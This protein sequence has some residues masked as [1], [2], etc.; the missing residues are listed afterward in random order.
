MSTLLGVH[1]GG[2]GLW[3]EVTRADP[4]DQVLSR[5]AARDLW[6]PEE[7]QELWLGARQECGSSL[8]P[9]LFASRKLLRN[10]CGRWQVPPAPPVLPSRVTLLYML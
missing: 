6:F 4:S 7:Q 10:P 5:V 2:P 9:S 8:H 1:G 3:P